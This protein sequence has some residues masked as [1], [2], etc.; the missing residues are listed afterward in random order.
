MA[1]GA[2]VR[3]DGVRDN[4]GNNVQNLGRS[5]DDPR[6][7]GAYSYLLKNCAGLNRAGVKVNH[8]SHSSV[9]GSLNGGKLKLC[10]NG[11]K[12]T[13]EGC[14]FSHECIKKPCK[15]GNECP[16][17]DKCLFNHTS[18]GNMTKNGDGRA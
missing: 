18:V 4:F 12:C 3:S 17:T 13:T 8:Q 11:Q 6:E 15:F 14:S 1:S 5:F 16:R 10:R 7:T 2:P 9:F